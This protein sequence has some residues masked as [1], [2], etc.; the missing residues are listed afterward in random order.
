MGTMSRSAE[1]G[2]TPARIFSKVRARTLSSGTRARA[3]TQITDRIGPWSSSKAKR[4]AVGLEGDAGL[5]D[6]RRDQV[7][8]RGDEV[9]GQP[10][11]DLLVGEDRLPVALVADVVAEL[12]AAGDEVPGLPL[13]LLAGDLD[14]VPIE[15]RAVGQREP[16]RRRRHQQ[17]RR[18]RPGQDQTLPHARPAHGHLPSG[19]CSRSIEEGPGTTGLRDGLGP[20]R[21]SDRTYEGPGDPSTRTNRP[22]IARPPWCSAARPPYIE[23]TR[24]RR[25]ERHALPDGLH[26][27][28]ADLGLRGRCPP[29]PRRPAGLLDHAAARPPEHGQRRR[30]RR[31]DRLGPLG[32]RGERQGGASGPSAA[33][34]PRHVGRSTAGPS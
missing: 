15:G 33:P 21:S 9:L 25:S 1:I 29:A 34:R 19:G 5:V 22:G 2:I 24:R 26:R 28:P 20:D 10:G 11:V 16:D 30:G 7:G 18:D 23:D 14:E 8:E 17:D 4:H 3:T 12:Q 13:A 31:A 6:R 32:R 27:D